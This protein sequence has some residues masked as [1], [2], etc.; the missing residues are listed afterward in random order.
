[1]S[2][3]ERLEKATEQI[4]E[5]QGTIREILKEVHH[6]PQPLADCREGLTLAWCDLEDALATLHDVKIPEWW[7]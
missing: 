5:G 1:M 2:R 3:N 6:H 7:N 4:K